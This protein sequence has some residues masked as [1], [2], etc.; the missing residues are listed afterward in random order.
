MEQK[1]KQ[2]LAYT[3]LFILFIIL[4]FGCSPFE[5]GESTTSGETITCEFFYRS[6]A[7]SSLEP[8]LEI[9]FQQGSEQKEHQFEDMA[10]HARFQDYQFEG[11][12]LSI[13]VT[14]L[15]TGAEISRQLYQF[16][17]QN[18]LENQF[19]GGHGFTGLQYVYHPDSEAEMQ[20]F[21]SV[22]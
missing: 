1:M 8:A 22:E 11:R 3:S 16:D 4:I 2:V 6:S 7:G 12:A 9:T 19:I 21:C 18:P 15:E 17:P 13:A 10:F 5:P 20:Y 14:N